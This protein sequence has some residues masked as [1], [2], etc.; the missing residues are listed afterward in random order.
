[1]KTNLQIVSGILVAVMVTVFTAHI[2]PVSAATRIAT[3]THPNPFIS[4]TT[5]MHV[6]TGMRTATTA[7]RTSAG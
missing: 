3:S 1:M 5:R 4:S 6:P 2:I 7:I